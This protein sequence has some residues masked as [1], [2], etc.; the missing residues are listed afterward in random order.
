[1]EAGGRAGWEPAF[2]AV[3]ETSRNAIAIL[4]KEGHVATLVDVAH[5][6]AAVVRDVSGRPP[7]QGR[8]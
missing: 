5:A 8:A 1:M 4:D 7:E 3:F 6:L 2:R